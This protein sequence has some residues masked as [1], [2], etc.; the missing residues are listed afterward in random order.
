VVS[1]CVQKTVSVPV[2]NYLAV[3]ALPLWLEKAT[4]KRRLGA[5]TWADHLWSRSS[6]F[7]EHIFK[8]KNQATDRPPEA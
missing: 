3:S 2:W 4:W 7:L 6:M 8:P 1:F 5:A